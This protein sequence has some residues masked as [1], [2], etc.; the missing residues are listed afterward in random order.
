MA[1]KTFS[2]T[3][4][5]YREIDKRIIEIKRQLNQREGSPLDPLKVSKT[6]QK[7]VEGNHVINCCV[8]PRIPKGFR[9]EQHLR[10][11]EFFWDSSKIKL[12]LCEKQKKDSIGGHKL[13]QKLQGK[14]V[15]N[16]N[17]LDY[18]LANPYLIPKDWK[19]KF[20]FFWGTIYANPHGILYVRYLCWGSDRRW[21]WNN[22]CLGDDYNNKCPATLYN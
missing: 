12:Y 19:G 9:I 15:L 8:Y 3:G 14:A 1:G 4:D 13:R 11:G 6:L 10:S 21:I 16:A 17:V 7:I 20:V 18:L 5:Q 2:V 22:H